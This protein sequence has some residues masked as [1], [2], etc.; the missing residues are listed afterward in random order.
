MDYYPKFET[1]KEYE[2]KNFLLMDYQTRK[3]LELIENLFN[4]QKQGSILSSLDI[5]KTPMGKRLLKYYLKSPVYDIEK[6]IKRQNIIKTFLE[7]KNYFNDLDVLLNNIGDISR[8]STKISNKTISPLEFL[9]IKEGLRVLAEIET[10]QKKLNLNIKSS[11]HLDDYFKILNDTFEDDIEKIKNGDFIKYGNNSELDTLK[12]EL[13]EYENEIKEYENTLQ[14]L[15]EILSLKIN[16]KSGSYFIEIPN[17]TTKPISNDFM[18]VQKLKTTS[19]YTTEKLL[20]LDNKINLTINKI[21]ELRTNIFEN[22]KKYSTT[23]VDEIRNYSKTIA[24]LDVFYSMTKISVNYNFCCPKINKKDFS[25]ENGFHIGAKNLWENFTPLNIDFENKNF[26]LLT[27]TNGIGKS[28]LLKTVGTIIVLSQIGCFVPAKNAN[29]PLI[30]KLYT[31]LT[32]SDEIIGKKSTHQKQMN[33]ISKIIKNATKNSFILLDEIGKNTST[34]EGA[35]LNY[36]ISKYLVENIEAKTISS[37]HF[38][39]LKNLYQK[40]D[41]KI[42]FLKLN[43]KRE[44]EK[45]FLDFSKGIEIAKLENLPDEIINEAKLTLNLIQFN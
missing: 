41:N 29:L 42:Q 3:D 21:N 43:E 40:L 30:D 7:N 26:I 38:L 15:T 44:I 19:K 18:P 33:K 2:I 10:I 37:T 24:L 34:I 9:T 20:D 5:C 11:V 16:K 14:Q 28:T 23:I 6:I 45:G 13:K 22:L 35:S 32:V 36:S 31:V 25:I 27:G 4:N 39:N 17:S 12:S 1:I 8:L